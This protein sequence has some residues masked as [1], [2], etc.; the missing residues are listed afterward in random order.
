ML[1]LIKSPK[2]EADLIDIWLYIA[3][4]QTVN[5]DRL[6]DRLNDMACLLAET[7][8]MGVDR[9]SLCL[10]L[11]S[12]P[13]GSYILYYRVNGLELELVRVLSASRDTDGLSW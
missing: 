3:E 10:G 8:D 13:V 4:D 9:S 12:F 1:T 2:A 6:M 11:K 5:A 7:S